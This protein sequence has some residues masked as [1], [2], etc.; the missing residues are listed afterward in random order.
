MGWAA[1]Q[2]VIPAALAE[3]RKA[4]SLNPNEPWAHAALGYALIWKQ[5]QEAMA[6]CQ[7]AIALN[8]NFAVAH[9]FLAVALTVSGNC[10]DAFAHADTA[11]CLAQRD[12]LAHGYTGAP[13]NVRAAACFG[14]ENYRDG[15]D[16]ARKAIAYS[17]NLAS[18]YRCLLVNLAFHGQ[19]DE[20]SLIL[21]SV[22]RLC[23]NISVLSTKQD[24]GWAT[25]RARKRYAEAF[26]IAGL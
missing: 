14:I 9:Y 8:P 4:L 13:D 12:L 5:P 1:R 24:F 7:R 6:P 15:I 22:R 19:S 18:A 17:P 26:R 20:A 25:D 16:F 21:Q 10:N 11:E 23:P 3:A 2:K